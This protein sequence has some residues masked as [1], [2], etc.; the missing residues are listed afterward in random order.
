MKRFLLLA[1]T[2]SL[3]GAYAILAVATQRPRVSTEYR[4]YYIGGRTAF[5]R[6]QRY[7][8]TLDDGIDLRKRGLPTFAQNLSGVSYA[9][10]WGRWSDAKTGDGVRIEFEKAFT[11][12]VC[13]ELRARPSTTQLDQYV[14]LIFGTT[15]DMI[16]TSERGMHTYARTMRLA[17]ASDVLV[18]RP[19]A[20]APAEWDP[21]ALRT[22]RVALAIEN[23]RVRPMGCK[24]PQIDNRPA[25]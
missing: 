17:E 14:E 1:L 22:R 19:Q 13:I 7:R 20:P 23:I 24:N 12:D 15:E 2:A 3:L 11:G 10:K 18:I 5:W 8:A 25:K 4:D 16:K 6:P 9:E 21:L